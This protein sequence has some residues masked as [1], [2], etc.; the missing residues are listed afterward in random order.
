MGQD[1]VNRRGSRLARAGRGS[2]V[3]YARAVH[4]RVAHAPHEPDA[5]ILKLR[6]FPPPRRGPTDQ[7]RATPWESEHMNNP[8]PER[9]KPG[10]QS[11]GDLAMVLRKRLRQNAGNPNVLR[12]FRAWSIRIVGRSPGRCP[13][14]I[15]RAPAGQES[16]MHNF[17][18][19]QRGS[20]FQSPRWRVGFVWWPMRLWCVQL[21]G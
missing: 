2:G 13:G 15:C 11:Q 14:L 7:P 10:A 19:R 21:I 20:P 9:A 6:F 16:K 5:P 17:K 18:T 12:P 4:A 8:C 3:S 1:L